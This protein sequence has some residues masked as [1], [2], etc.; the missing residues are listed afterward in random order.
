[1][2]ELAMRVLVVIE[3]KE[4]HVVGTALWIAGH[5]ALTARHVLSDI[6]RRFGAGSRVDGRSQISDYAVRLLQIVD[7]SDYA[8]WDVDM[9]WSSIES[10]IALLHVKLW[11]SSR[12]EHSPVWRV[13]R[14]R[15]VAPPVGSAIVAFGYHSSRI[16]LSRNVNGGDHI[17][18]MDIPSSSTGKV[19]EV[20][21]TGQP[22]GKF[23]F[24]CFRVNARFDGAMSGG[25]VVDEF[26]NVCGIVS[27]T[28]GNLDGDQISYVATLW[29]MLRV[30]ISADRGQNY[31][32]G[33]EY[34][35]IDLA[36]DAIIAVVDLK[37]LDPT[38]F[39]GKALPK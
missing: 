20:L 14:F 39:P 11:G 4:A 35:V 36:L 31:P 9:A 30:L 19:D 16:S 28:M 32:R 27:G 29:P 17:D 2:A 3:G 25:P 21:P 8:I 7:G 5:L 26:G 23:S 6:I 18:L 13:P 34:P 15:V 33:V 10:D 1:M 24:P 37:E 38:F 22:A 12:E